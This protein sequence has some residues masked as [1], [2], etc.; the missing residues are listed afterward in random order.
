MLASALVV[1]LVTFPLVQRSKAL[2]QARILSTEGRHEEA[3]VLL[4]EAVGQH[5]ESPELR[6]QAEAEA[7]AV[8]EARCA[9]DREDAASWLEG[10]VRRHAY[11]DALRTELKR[12]HRGEIC[13]ERR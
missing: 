3:L 8:V 9:R 7:R 12:T 13:G 4:D 10:Q 2:K 11:L 6:Y 5:P 1:A